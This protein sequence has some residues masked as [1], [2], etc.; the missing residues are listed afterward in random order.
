[1]VAQIE[2]NAAA[3]GGGGGGGGG[4]VGGSSPPVDESQE[5]LEKTKTLICALNFLSRN[6]PI[7]P[8]V[9]DAVSSIYNSDAN[10]VD[11]GDGDASPA[12]VDSLSVQNG[13]GMGSYGDLMADLEES[14]LSQ[15][16]SYTSGSGLTKLKEDRFRSH[17]QHRL[18]ELEDLPTSRGEDL[19][20]KCLL[21]LYE[22]KLADLQQKVR[23]EVSSEYWL[24]LHCANPDK[25]LF[26]WGMTRLR[27]PVYGIGDAF[28]VE[29]DDP[30]R[31][32]RD[33]QR[34]SRIEEEERNRVETTKRKFFADV[35]NAARELQ[36][37]VQAVQK[38]RKQRNDGVQAWH[39]RQRQRATR[40]EK[41]RL[42]ALKADDQEAYMKM[43]EESK[44]ERLTML[45]GKTN[46]LLGRL[47]AAVQRQKDADHDGLESLEGSDAEMAAT[48]TDTP[49]QSLPEEE[50]D[51]IDDESTHDVKTND[52]LEGQRKYNSAVHSIQEIGRAHV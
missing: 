28:A 10:D 45:L 39:G 17:I 5:Q 40:A 16:S 35:L 25:Q 18:T 27:R 22:L 34:L 33:A 47:G 4:M 36:L 42:Q 49:G 20:S 31:K 6:L 46:D 43:V 15:R 52:L 41:L 13:P 38:R 11:V 19:Q 2:T 51:V 3:D 30:L 7:P 37:Q 24:R 29:S 26:D 32:K 21:E 14:L 12:D 44:N 9:F 23:S 50:E 8:D 1:M 48:K